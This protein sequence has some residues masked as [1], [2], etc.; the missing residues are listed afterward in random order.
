MENNLLILQREMYNLDLEQDTQV[1]VKFKPLTDRL[2]TLLKDNIEKAV[3]SKR[4]TTSPLAI[5]SPKHGLSGHA[6][7]VLDAQGV[8][9]KNP[10]M[11]YMM[12]HMRSQ[13]KILEI[14]PHHPVMNTLLEY[15]E[16]DEVTEEMENLIQ[17][18]YETTSIKSGFPLKDMTQFAG[19][20]ENLI[21]NTVGISIQEKAKIKVKKTAE[22]TEKERLADEELKKTNIIYEVEE[23]EVDHGEL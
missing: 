6:Q 22:K 5:I 9:H 21:R 12:E 20:V 1:E 10:N 23:E 15:V 2:H 16:E 13:K 11:E 19:C 18:M 3:V 17:L 7:R 14:N 4:L 8:N